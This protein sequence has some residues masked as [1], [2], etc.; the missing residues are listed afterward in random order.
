MAQVSDAELEAALRAAVD[1]DGVDRRVADATA[2][3]TAEQRLASE[4]N[5]QRW[6]EAAKSG[7][8]RTGDGKNGGV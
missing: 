3:L 8:K 1:D 7:R 2:G 4:R 6:I 5:I